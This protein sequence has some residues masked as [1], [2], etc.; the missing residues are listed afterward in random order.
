MIQVLSIFL[1]VLSSIELC[2]STIIDSKVTNITDS[3]KHEIQI[4]P[5][6]EIIE[7]I[8]TVW[9]TFEY[10]IRYWSS[11]NRVKFFMGTLN[12]IDFLTLMPFYLYLLLKHGNILMNSNK[13]KRIFQEFLNIITIIS[14]IL[15]T[16]RIFKLTR[17]SSALRTL[18]RTLRK[19]NRELGL[20]VLFL[21]IGVF[22]FSGF[23]YFAGL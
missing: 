8:C 5:T 9:F 6:Y 7:I 17:H 3:K 12:I 16:L 14:K 4:N 11:P 20:M 1:I 10:L 22:F 15:R 2:L 13:T 18:A 23:I 19:N 21:S